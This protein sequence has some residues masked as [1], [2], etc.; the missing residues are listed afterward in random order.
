M[1]QD[2]YDFAFSPDPV[3]E[4]PFAE[5]GAQDSAPAAE[6][7]PF[8]AQAPPP[9]TPSIA[10]TEAKAPLASPVLAP[11]ASPAASPRVAPTP[12]PRVAVASPRGSPQPSPRQ[13]AR[14][15][16]PSPR[17]APAEDIFGEMEPASNAPQE[18]LKFE[19]KAPECVAAPETNVLAQWQAK[20][21]E[22][23]RKRRD[24]AREKKEQQKVTAKDETAKFLAER[25]A[26]I[27]KTKITNV[28]EEKNFTTDMATLMEHGSQWEKV[29]KLINLQPKP[30]EKPGTSRKDRMRA[31]LIQLKHEK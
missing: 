25:E 31:L 6:V 17:G 11:A 20:R 19:E 10:V 12:S 2:H 23:L 14:P 1:S 24:A 22:E 8:A 7:D 28:E 9:S 16:T 30:N 27:E 18:E 5:Q 21:Q 29:H 26:K 13:G 3:N 15:V 4:D